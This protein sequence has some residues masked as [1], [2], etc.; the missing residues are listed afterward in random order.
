MKNLISKSLLLLMLLL[1]SQDLLGQKRKSSRL[2]PSYHVTQF[3]DRIKGH[4]WSKVDFTLNSQVRNSM[5]GGRYCANIN[6]LKQGFSDA[7]LYFMRIYLRT[8]LREFPLGTEAFL[9]INN[10]IYPVQLETVNSAFHHV[11]QESNSVDAQGNPTVEISTN[12]FQVFRKRADISKVL[13]EVGEVKNAA[14]TVYSG[15]M[16]IVF[17]FDH[18][19]IQKLELILEY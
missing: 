11:K 4:L 9:T 8:G 1:S 3:E 19:D 18:L 6:I 15:E 10:V 2:N 7:D 14:L 5:T 17:P 13:Y 12:E 16:P